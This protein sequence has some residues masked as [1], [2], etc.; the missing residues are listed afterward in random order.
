VVAS[1]QCI[2]CRRTADDLGHGAML[3][4]RQRPTHRSSY[5]LCLEC[6]RRVRE[7]QDER[8]RAADEQAERSGT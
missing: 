6:A 2:A 5:Q 7:E 8:V 4:T 3:L 1:D